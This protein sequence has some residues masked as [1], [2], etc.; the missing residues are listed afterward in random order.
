MGRSKLKTEEFQ[1]GSVTN[2]CLIISLPAEYFCRGDLSFVGGT[3]DS[4]GH[5]AY[6]LALIYQ[7]HHVPRVSH[8]SLNFTD[9]II[10]LVLLYQGGGEDT[11]LLGAPGQQGLL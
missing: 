7:D 11:Y 5:H 2:A 10:P 8:S 9:N 3:Y 4:G 6:L 1:L